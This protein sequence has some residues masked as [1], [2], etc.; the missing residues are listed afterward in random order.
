MKILYLGHYKESSGWSNAAINQILA[1]DKAGLDV[2]CRDVKLTSNEYTLDKR[3]E[4][5]E[6]KSIDNV[7]VCIQHLLPHHYVY[8]EKFKKNVAY[9]VAETSEMQHNIWYPQLELMDE[10][11]V[12]NNMMKNALE[13]SKF[14]K[15]VRVVP[16]AFNIDDYTKEYPR[17]NF[18][19]QNH[20]FKFYY[21][22]ELNDRKNIESIIRAFHSEFKPYEQVSL[23]LKV[24]GPN[25]QLV[26][27]QC[28]KICTDI[29]NELRIHSKIQDYKNE[30]LITDNT[31]NNIIKS[32]HVSCDC[33]V[34]ASHGEAWSIPAFEAMC[35]G[36]TPIC[37]NEGG[38]RDF[39]D[40][41][42]KNTGYLLDGV[43]SICNHQNPAF[44]ELFT[45]NE[46][47]FCPSE[48]DLKKAMRFYYENKES[49]NHEDGLSRAKNYSYE[50][51]GNLVKE[52]LND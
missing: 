15:P 1:L 12:P 38:P 40:S 17:L 46:T 42:N 13:D 33:F 22:G 36:K 37:S 27:E 7:D 4:A 24:K 45:G 23:V 19:L 44:K 2:V 39:I 3:I 8:T 16:H 28:S 51:I 50:N 43:Y 30:I 18:G 49:I 26:K 25:P 9:F 34:S 32:L 11:W 41:S 20:T 10:I 14:I 35:F 52:I 48:K 6:R 21:I 31:D 29:K 47:W 5:L